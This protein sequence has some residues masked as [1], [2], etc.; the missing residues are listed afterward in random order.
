MTVSGLRT[1]RTKDFENHDFD[2]GLALLPV[3]NSVNGFNVNNFNNGREILKLYVCFFISIFTS[4]QQ[5]VDVNLAIGIFLVTMTN[6][7]R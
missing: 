3:G 5:L 4:N 6:R 2:L 1:P 7:E